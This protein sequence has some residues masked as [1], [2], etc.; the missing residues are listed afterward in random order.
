MKISIGQCGVFLKYFY[1]VNLFK[2]YLLMCY[3]IVSKNCQLKKCV[4]NNKEKEY[5]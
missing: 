1:L 2:M 3:L 5:F 4:G